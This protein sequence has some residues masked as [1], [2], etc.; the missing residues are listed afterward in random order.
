[1][2]TA[3]V[4]DCTNAETST[5]Y[6]SQLGLRPTAAYVTLNRGQCVTTSHTLQEGKS[7]F[8][9]VYNFGVF[10]D[11]EAFSRGAQP[12]GTIMIILANEGDVSGA[13]TALQEKILTDNPS[14]TAQ[15]ITVQ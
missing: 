11:A 14:L 8:Q 13:W 15:D 10:N 9:S 3:L 1:M 5:L 7:V 6:A 12:I 2:T 4:V